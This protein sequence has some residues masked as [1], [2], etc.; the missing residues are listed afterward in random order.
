MKSE[1]LERLLKKIKQIQ[2]IMVDVSTGGS[3]LQDREDEYIVI[4]LDISA[5]IESR[6][7]SIAQ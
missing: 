4:Y 3:L 7:S 1:Q 6:A 2:S 5:E